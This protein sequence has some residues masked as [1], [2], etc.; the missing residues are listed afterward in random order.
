MIL[1]LSLPCS[2][3][4]HFSD[5]PSSF[6]I[7]DDLGARI[8]VLI[9]ILY[10]SH[11]RLLLKVHRLVAQALELQQA[12][13]ILNPLLEPLR[14]GIK[15]INITEARIFVVDDAHAAH[16]H[17]FFGVDAGDGWEPSTDYSQVGLFEDEAGL[18]DAFV[19]IDKLFI[20]VN[21]LV[22]V[23]LSKEYID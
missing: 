10:Q 18:V 4:L 17:D 16:D 5:N 21:W 1:N 19:S 6:L 11:D 20:C 12:G 14:L 7:L 22:C 13:E 9:I 3:V 8:F 15:D 23:I 2:D